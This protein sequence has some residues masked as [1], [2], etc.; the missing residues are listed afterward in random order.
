MKGPL[1]RLDPAR[2]AALAGTAI[3]QARPLQ[4]RLDGR[5]I[6][7]F[8]GDTVLSAVLAAGIDSVGPR[9]DGP[10]ALSARFA[11][12]IVPASRGRGAQRP[13]S[14]AR[15]PAT[16]GADYATIGVHDS[17]LRSGRLARLFRPA[18]SLGLRLDAPEGLPVPWRTMPGANGPSADLI[19]VGGGVAG[20][21]A[22]LAAA[23]AGLSVI[24]LEA[25]PFLGGHSRLFGTLD[26][27]ETPDAAITRMSAAIADSD[28]ITVLHNAEV[29]AARA[30]V[31]RAHVTT[32]DDGVVT[33]SVVDL[34]S[35]A[36]V[37]ACGTVE[38]LPVFAGNRLPGTV[39]T[40]EAFALAYHYGVWP[41]QSAV[42]ATASSAAYRLAM[43]AN[44]AGIATRRI[45]DSRP[46]PQSR[47]IEFSRAYGITQTT[48]SIIAAAE[49]SR[50]GAGLDIVPQL[51]SGGAL[52][53]STLSADRLVLCGGWQPDL[54]LWHMAGGASRWAADSTRLEPQGQL[55]GLALAG[56]AAGWLS[57]Q[58][59][60]S[61][62]ADAVAQLFGHKR[63]AV[64]ERL[65]DPIYETPD[66]PTAI[67]DA[68]SGSAPAFLDAGQRQSRRMRVD[69]RSG[70]ATVLF[71]TKPRH[72]TAPEPLAVADVAASVQL[73]LVPAVSAGIVA[74]ERVAMVSLGGDE[75]PLVAD[76]PVA[77]LV[78]EFL[79]GRFGAHP[80]LWTIASSDGRLFEIGALIQP[81]ADQR[82]PFAA[83][84]VVVR[85]DRAGAVALVAASHA[86]AGRQLAL[87]ENGRSTAI[88][89]VSALEGA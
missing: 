59:C 9:N 76:E 7:G 33:A 56:S 52:P 19:V 75:T 57:R 83:V 80:T 5:I 49:P 1:A 64:T 24:L 35:K 82:D 87:L 62:G 69:Q 29:F 3:D 13:L 17:R 61:S 28:A 85:A 36:I 14:M 50:S 81:D 31:V 68:G 66:A 88:S 38:R 48:G 79:A 63:V 16:D 20:M 73:G 47:F 37:L 67:A 54:T 21:A 39:G 27:E 18:R 65:L 23:K 25:S 86:E 4:F 89:L 34:T 43:L 71:R 78:P 53:D 84:G 44:D 26:G 6:A 74:R 72:A 40:L 51:A 32:L 41:G 77:P 10:L 8:A 70:L 2:S 12:A 42:F 11:P 55:A 58:A 30:G 15:T 22:S 45:I 46:R 60:A